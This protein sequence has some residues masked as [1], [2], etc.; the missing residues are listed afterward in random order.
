LEGDHL[1]IGAERAEETREEKG[2][3]LLKERKF[4]KMSRSIRLPKDVDVE[5]T[6]TK[7]ENGELSITLPRVS[8]S[9]VPTINIQ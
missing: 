3:Y 4:A 9:T 2:N 7:S 6:L 5:H 1:T 8:K